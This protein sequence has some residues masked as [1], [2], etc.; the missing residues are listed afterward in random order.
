MAL[1]DRSTA[2]WEAHA[3]QM[4]AANDSIMGQPPTSGTP[5][6][7]QEL[8]TAESHGLHDYRRGQFAK[9]I[10]EIYRDWI[11]PHIQ[12]KITQ[13][14][15]F[16]SELTLDELQYVSESVV[17]NQVNT[18][19]KEIILNGGTVTPEQQ[20]AFTQ[21]Y[22]DEFNKK[23]NKRFIE[24]LKGE[25]KDTPLGVKVSVQGK[26]KDLSSR[27]DKLVNIFRT[28]VANPAVLRLPPIAKIFNDIIEASGLDPA[29]FSQ[30]TREQIADAQGVAP[31]Q[32]DQQMQE[33]PVAA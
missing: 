26:S 12:R 10:E 32:E 7:L 22:K 5:F 19:I 6:K 24:I 29:D 2:N 20:A 27:T 33:A 23:G 4:G 18:R 14:T 31:E 8:V 28:V 3:Q 25:F 11:I 16:L 15:K 1:F 17:T 13:G 9:H 21:L 30:I